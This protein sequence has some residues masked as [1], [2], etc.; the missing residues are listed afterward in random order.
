LFYRSAVADGDGDDIAGLRDKTSSYPKSSRGVYCAVV[1]HLPELS[2]T[3]AEQVLAAWRSAHEGYAASSAQSTR[4]KAQKLAKRFGTSKKPRKGQP[5]EAQQ[6]WLGAG[7]SSGSAF[8]TKH[9]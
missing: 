5:L 6:D 9:D 2:K 1:N 3:A 7:E 8:L 4:K